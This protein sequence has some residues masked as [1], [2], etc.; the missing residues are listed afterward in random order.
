[1]LGVKLS[2]ADVQEQKTQEPSHGSPL[3]VV[4]SHVVV[5]G[6]WVASRSYRRQE[7]CLQVSNSEKK[8]LTKLGRVDIHTSL[9]L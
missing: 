9:S 4:F 7:S 8:R 2:H 5:R 3:Y 6:G 1:M